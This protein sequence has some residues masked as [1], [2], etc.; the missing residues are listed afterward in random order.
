[1][2]SIVE[3]IVEKETERRG[4]A[5]TSIKSDKMMNEGEGANSTSAVNGNQLKFSM[6]SYPNKTTY[7][8]VADVDE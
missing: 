6:G 3:P 4:S 5:I 8:A 1:M 2:N 7:T